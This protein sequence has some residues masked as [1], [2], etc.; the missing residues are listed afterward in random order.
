LFAAAHHPSPNP[1]R[2]S[3]P[4]SGPDEFDGKLVYGYIS[5][6]REALYGS[7][8]SS[9]LHHNVLD[10]Y[11]R[12][13]REAEPTFRRPGRWTTQSR[14][15]RRS[16]VPP[17]DGTVTLSNVCLPLGWLLP[18][19]CLLAAQERASSWLSARVNSVPP[20]PL[21]PLRAT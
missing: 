12:A 3:R 15:I 14:P 4:S 20:C 6:S 5:E 17:L 10:F 9:Q 19:S 16:S 2:G 8:P 11:Y 13:M 18:W 7:L 21:S 1:G